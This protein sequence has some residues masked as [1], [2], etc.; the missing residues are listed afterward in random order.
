MCVRQMNLTGVC[1]M[2]GK[3]KRL[4]KQGSQLS[5]STIQTFW[6]A[7]YVPGHDPHEGQSGEEDPK[8]GVRE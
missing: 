2:D 5:S 6:R 3:G 7:Y 1:R 4:G 8:H